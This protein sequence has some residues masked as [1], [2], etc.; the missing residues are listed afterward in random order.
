MKKMMY[1]A[2]FSVS[3]LLPCFLNAQEAESDNEEE[4]AESSATEQKGKPQ[5]PAGTEKNGENAESAKNAQ[6]NGL[7]KD[8]DIAKQQ[9]KIDRL[10]TQLKKA[11]KQ[12]ERKRCEESLRLEQNKLRSILKKK[13]D[14]LKADIPHC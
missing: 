4:S 2:V 11:K 7:A 9:K 10:L 12:S 3:L 13:T 5:K 14:P 8:S 6:E 1:A